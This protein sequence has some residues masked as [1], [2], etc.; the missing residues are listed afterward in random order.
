MSYQ[1]IKKK[2]G[3]ELVGTCLLTGPLS[4]ENHD[5]MIKCTQQEAKEIEADAN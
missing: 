3:E 2:E 5:K 4:P 1:I